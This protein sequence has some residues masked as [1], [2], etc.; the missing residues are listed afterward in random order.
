MSNIGSFG[1]PTSLIHS[2]FFVFTSYVCASMLG[3]SNKGSSSAGGTLPEGEKPKKHT[4]ASSS[5]SV[6][7]PHEHEK[8]MMERIATSSGAND[9]RGGD[10]NSGEEDDERKKVVVR[11]PAT[12]ANVGPGF[13]SIGSVYTLC[14][15]CCLVA[16]TTVPLQSIF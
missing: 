8:K 10:E 16:A 14:F 2:F 1:G 12:S 7:L 15:C 11:V 4:P 3:V 9:A 6:T 13:D 5:S